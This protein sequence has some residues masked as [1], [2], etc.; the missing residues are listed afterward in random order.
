MSL[1]TPKQAGDASIQAKRVLY[2][3]QEGIDWWYRVSFATGD[4]NVYTNANYL[5]L[6]K[7]G[8]P[9]SPPNLTQL[10]QLNFEVEEYVG[11]FTRNG[12]TFIWLPITYADTASRNKYGYY[13]TDDDGNIISSVPPITPNDDYGGTGSAKSA[14]LYVVICLALKGCAN[15]TDKIYNWT[16]CRIVYSDFDN[17]L[18]RIDTDKTNFTSGCKNLF[19]NTG[20][21]VF[22]VFRLTENTF[23]QT[24][25]FGSHINYDSASICI[26]DKLGTSWT[27]EKLI[28]YI[29][30]EVIPTIID[31]QVPM[32]V[33]R[34]FGISRPKT[35]QFVST[36]ETN[37]RNFYVKQDYSYDSSTGNVVNYV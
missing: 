18:E 30:D 31:V 17:I 10:T 23:P 1:I 12:K 3:C 11:E 37:P 28:S 8:L 9:K 22:T 13:K 26:N 20:R 15:I 29:E 2:N 7:I 34:S 32:I 14:A 35:Q 36:S 19:D 4:Y 27:K 16:Q 25:S 24:S 5:S 21:S 6:Y 33:L